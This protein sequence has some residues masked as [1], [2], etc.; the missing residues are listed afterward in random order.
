MKLN[1]QR[2]LLFSSMTTKPL[3]SNYTILTVNEG[4]VAPTRR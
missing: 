4:R 1:A 2:S 3:K